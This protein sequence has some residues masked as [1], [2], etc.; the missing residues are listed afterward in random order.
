MI[1]YDLNA[2]R[3]L[4]EGASLLRALWLALEGRL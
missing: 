4:A 2:W 3:S 1:S